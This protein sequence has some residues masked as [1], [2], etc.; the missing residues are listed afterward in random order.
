MKT[1]LDVM[2]TTVDNPY[3]P[4]DEFD[5]WFNYDNL[6]GYN[7]CGIVARIAPGVDEYSEEFDDDFRI[8]SILRFVDEDPLHI[9][10][11]VAKEVPR[12]PARAKAS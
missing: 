3:N 7:C 11:Y 8:Q 9:Y 1:K 6:K 5:K 2:L 4:F 10:T 12:A